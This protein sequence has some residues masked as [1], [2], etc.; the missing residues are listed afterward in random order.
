MLNP[1]GLAETG[2]WFEYSF[3]H[4]NEWQIFMPVLLEKKCMM[5]GKSFLEKARTCEQ[6]LVAGQCS[7]ATHT[8]LDPSS[9][10]A[11]LL[12]I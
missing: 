11:D 6:K 7:L 8:K 1:K 2:N 3:P 10:P 5:L 9:L 4:F 12:I